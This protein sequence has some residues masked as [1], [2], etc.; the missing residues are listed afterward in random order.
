MQRNTV[1]FLGDGFITTNIFML[2]VSSSK[3]D[4]FY[5]VPWFYIHI[6]FLLFLENQKTPTNTKKK[7]WS[8]I[9]LDLPEIL[10]ITC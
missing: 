9:I 3:C 8:A 1:I 2:V 10:A 4:M 7:M 5:D 6:S